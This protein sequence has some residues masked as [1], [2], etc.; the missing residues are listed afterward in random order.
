MQTKRKTHKRYPEGV[1]CYKVDEGSHMQLSRNMQIGPKKV[2]FIVKK[3]IIIIIWATKHFPPKHVRPTRC[4]TKD[5]SSFSRGFVGYLSY[6][7]ET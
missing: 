6:Y 2:P 4:W 3:I 7:N 5:F 1:V